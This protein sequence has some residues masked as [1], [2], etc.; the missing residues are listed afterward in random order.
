[1]NTLKTHLFRIARAGIAAASA[2]DLVTRALRD[3]H[4]GLA[5]PGSR[6]HVIAAGKA[7]SPMARALLEQT[8]AVANVLAVGTHREPELPN[9][10]EWHESSHPFPDERSVRAAERALEVARSVA[11]H[12]DLLLLLSGG[13]SSLLAAPV[14]G[15]SL[16][17]KRRVVR[18]LINGGADIYAL[19]AV[20][21]HVS[22]VKGGRLAAACLGQFTTLAVS[23]VV[24]DDL[25]VIGSGPGV[26]DPSTWHDALEAYRRWTPHDAR[27]PHVEALLEGG[28]AGAHADTPKPGDPT[29]ARSAAR[30]IGGRRDAMRGARAE[31]DRLGYEVI[32]WDEPITGEARAIAPDWIAK[33]RTM[34]GDA[35]RPMCVI[36]SGETTVR[37]H[38][39]GK[40]GR[41]QEFALAMTPLVASW[42]GPLAVASVGT[43]GIDGPT[44]AAGAVADSTTLTRAEAL[45]L[46]VPAH[47]LDANDS[48]AFFDPLGDLIRTGR[49]DTNVGDL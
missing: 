20:R 22:L 13:A 38:G 33:A 23:D 17:D 42:P 8:P 34:V 5:R 6:L 45:S 29:L 12:E 21:K 30:V 43:D 46:H 14:E 27:L 37:V 26:P 47:Y 24:G 10:V 15:L 11:P 32:V 39:R 16:G 4:R 41:N 36:S 44:D 7:A 1:M 2:H 25:S 35:G 31:A 3:D 28:A 18:G 40:G 48:Y 19:N 49:T 9:D